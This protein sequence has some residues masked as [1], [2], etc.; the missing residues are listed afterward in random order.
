MD[1]EA[2]VAELRHTL[3]SL[4]N[5]DPELAGIWLRFHTYSAVLR[6]DVTSQVKNVPNW[7]ELVA[8]YVGDIDEGVPKPSILPFHSSYKN[9]IRNKWM[10]GISSALAASVVVALSW[11]IYFD[12]VGVETIKETQ[13]VDNQSA[14]F[15]TLVTST[16]EELLATQETFDVAPQYDL[17]TVKYQLS[18]QDI[19]ELARFVQEQNRNSLLPR[20]TSGNLIHTVSSQNSR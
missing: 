11:L 9:L 10:A 4:E 1:G 7:D 8:G 14:N 18:Q 19:R 15:E 13:I 16:S 20:Q 6:G 5:S 2:D 3:D 17:Q 12:D